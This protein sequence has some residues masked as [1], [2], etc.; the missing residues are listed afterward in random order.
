MNLGALLLCAVAASSAAIAQPYP[1]RPIRWVAP[2]ASGS[3]SDI[4][5][6]SP[7]QLAQHLRSETE[8]Y[9]KIVKASGA[10]VD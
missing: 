4:V 7:E 5:A 2:S 10:K 8:K 1:S 6:S 3:T 9:A